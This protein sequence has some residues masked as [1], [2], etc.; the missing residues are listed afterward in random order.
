MAVL[1][2]IIYKGEPRKAYI[3]IQAVNITKQFHDG[4]KNYAV[5][6]EIHLFNNQEKEHFLDSTTIVFT[7]QNIFDLE[8]TLWTKIK[9]KYQGTD[10]I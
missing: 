1:S 4:E 6:A 10:L 8:K 3:C 2:D 9:E 7:M 5:F